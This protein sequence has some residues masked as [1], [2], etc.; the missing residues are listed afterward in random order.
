MKTSESGTYH[1]VGFYLPHSTDPVILIVPRSVLS[2]SAGDMNQTIVRFQTRLEMTPLY[3]HHH[4]APRLS[5]HRLE[6]IRVRRRLTR[7][8]VGT[9]IVS[10]S[11][12]EVAHFRLKRFLNDGVPRP[13][14]VGMPILFRIITFFL[15]LG[16][17]G[18]SSGCNFFFFLKSVFG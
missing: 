6:F 15:Y 16:T 12:I 10:R 4:F 8:A 7:T 5:P 14:T 13:T 17:W 18:Y 9:S 2:T 3:E 11:T 1:P